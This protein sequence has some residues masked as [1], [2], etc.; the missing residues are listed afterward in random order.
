MNLYKLE[1]MKMKLSAYLLA[2]LI[3][4][5]CIASL[6]ILFLFISQIETPEA[7][8]SDDEMFSSWN[9]LFALTT[10]LTFSCFSVVSAAVA[11]KVIVG[12]Y[13]GANAVML[14]SYPVGRRLILKTKCGI[15]CGVTAV[16]AFIS[17]VLA[18]GVMYFIAEIFAL[19]I[20]AEGEH[21]II[22]VLISSILTGVVSS[23]VGI[24][25]AAAG[26]KKRSVIATIICAII[27]VCALTNL[28]AV[29]PN[30]IIFVLYAMSVIFILAA[31]LMYGILAKGIDRM[32]I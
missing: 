18:A 19:Q 32:E 27:I 31:G 26:W 17:N 6:G 22:I 8:I 10:A 1:L 9:G 2:I 24:I 25:S 12:E 3:V 29:S 28:I 21:F 16:F 11:A 4:F 7:G 15:V 30:N 5:V 23:A 20:E 14:L 13:C